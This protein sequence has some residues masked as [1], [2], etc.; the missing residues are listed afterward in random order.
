MTFSLAKKAQNSGVS[1]STPKSSATCPP[2]P[3]LSKTDKG[4]IALGVI[5]GLFVIGLL[6]YGL[7]YF[8]LKPKGSETAPGGK[9]GSGGGGGADKPLD[10][11][12]FPKN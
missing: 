6:A 8:L 12:L 5:V 1:R 4:L 10:P 3:A 2:Q 11:P 9:A 7:Y